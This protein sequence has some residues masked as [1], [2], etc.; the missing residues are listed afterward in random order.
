MRSNRY[1]RLTKDLFGGEDSVERTFEEV[2]L[3]F[4]YLDAD[5]VEG[6]KLRESITSPD[7]RRN[8]EDYSIR[9]LQSQE[10]YNIKMIN[11][12][13]SGFFSPGDSEAYISFEGRPDEHYS[14]LRVELGARSEKELER[15]SSDLEALEK[16]LE[17][18]FE[19]EEV[20]GEKTDRILAMD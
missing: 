9:E 14:H 17:N 12:G 19:K 3:P 1:S 7:V 18:Y 16:G 6:E 8:M 20:S 13:S 11:R 2:N 4:D 10:S 5:Q 15:I